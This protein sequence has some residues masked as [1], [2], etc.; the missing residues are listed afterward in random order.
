ML[1]TPPLAGS[2]PSLAR[3]IVL[4]AVASFASQALVR[5]A[6]PLLPQI[7]ADF[8]VTV[9]Q[10]AIVVT[11]YAVTHGSIQLV[12]GPIGDRFGKYRAIA[13]ACA[14]SAVTVALCGFARSLHELAF[15]RFASGLT[16]AWILPLGLAFIG[17]V[18]P[19]E[20]R[21]HV[22]G[23]FLAGQV[24][25]Q[26]FGQAA[27]GVI[28]DYLGWRAVF[29]LL[30]LMF[31]VAA[32]ALAVELAANPLTRPRGTAQRPRGLRADYASIF[33]NRW[34]R[35]VLLVVFLEGTLLQGVFSFVGADLHL[36][37]GLSFAAIG[38]IVACFGLGGLAYA[39]A[40]KPLM[41][42]L[43]QAGIANGGGL[44]MAAA[45]LTLAMQPVWW[46]APLAVLLIGLGFYMLHNT[47]QTVGTQMAPEARGTSV[48]L[49][50]SL[51]FLGQ[52]TGVTVAAPVMDRFGGPPL[53]MVSALLLPVL[54]FWFT[55]RLRR[56]G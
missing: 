2:P 33:T 10:A 28:G 7:A 45:F 46:P 6:N 37:F 30:A 19:Y 42:R 54:A 35:F 9:G 49:F 17:D 38:L 43:G 40:V 11:A 18:V 27:G 24:L 20:Q 23:R 26:L 29:F 12:I 5:A 21:Q 15:A 41:D 52:T 39:A 34:A 22:L 32:A 51:Y 31:A 25:G 47:L 48:A 44:F 14:V 16:I 56:R 55:R 1:S 13:A 53:F 50:A 3:A 8:D 4:L 36:R